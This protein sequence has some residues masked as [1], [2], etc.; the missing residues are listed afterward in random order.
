[1]QAWA[2]VESPVLSMLQDMPPNS[3]EEVVMVQREEA[4]T[5]TVLELGTFHL[6]VGRA[7][8]LMTIKANSNGDFSIL[9][10]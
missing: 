2:W 8:K 1:M 3:T 6:I 7:Q 4:E 5:S 10:C 9:P